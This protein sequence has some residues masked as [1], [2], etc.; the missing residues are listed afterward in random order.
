MDL[1]GN[2]EAQRRLYGAPLGELLGGYADRLGLTQARLAALLGV[3]PPMLSQLMNARR[4]KIGN[5]AAAQRLQLLHDLVPEVE[6]GAMDVDQLVAA[7]ESTPGRRRPD[8]DVDAHVGPGA[9]QHGPGGVPRGRVGGPTSSTLRRRSRPRTRGS[10]SCCG[11]TAPSGPSTRSR[12]TRR[13]P[14][15]DRH[16]GLRG[17]RRPQSG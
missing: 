13:T 9:R 15:A 5:P 7:V 8:A 11:S 6:S 3:S 2:R 14:E 17:H 12:T 4:I 1:D 10:P 16:R